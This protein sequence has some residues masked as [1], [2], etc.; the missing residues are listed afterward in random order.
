MTIWLMRRRPY[1]ALVIF[2]LK[3]SS[4]LQ[5]LLTAMRNLLRS[6]GFPEECGG[7]HL[8][9]SYKLLTYRRGYPWKEM[10]G[11]V[12]LSSA[13]LPALFPKGRKN[14]RWYGAAVVSMPS[15]KLVNAYKRI[16]KHHLNSA[17]DSIYCFDD[18][19]MRFLSFVSKVA[20]WLRRNDVQGVLDTKEG[21]L[22]AIPKPGGN[23]RAV[24]WRKKIV[25]DSP[26]DYEPDRDRCGV[27]WLFIV[28]PCR[29]EVVEWA[30][31][32]IESTSSSFGFE[33][34][35]EIHAMSHRSVLV[36]LALLFDREIEREDERALQ[37]HDHIFESFVEEGHYPYRL[38]VQHAGRLPRSVDYYDQFL[39]VLKQAVDPHRV[40]APGRYEFAPEHSTRVE[41]GE[42]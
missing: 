23:L 40:L 28:L 10:A 1:F 21:P 30:T 13:M 26:E 18:R 29:P 38:G 5:A 14:V 42:R 8:V 24:Y 34:V 9:N 20:P 7:I 16:I 39:A 19:S 32:L 37:C 22:F 31:K 11:S 2:L 4:P 6:G 27:I 25:P 12:P 36:G 41:V 33:P 3:E 17:V 15:R 35:I